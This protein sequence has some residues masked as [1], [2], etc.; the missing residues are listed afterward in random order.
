MPEEDSIVTIRSRDASSEHHKE[1]NFTGNVWL[2]Q[3]VPEK[4]TAG[5]PP[6]RRVARV[7]FAPG[8]RTNWHI[9]P[10]GQV[11]FVLSGRGFVGSDLEVIEV[12]AEDAVFTPQGVRHWHGATPDSG[13]VH[14]AVTL[15]G[16]TDW[17]DPVTSE[18][19]KKG[20]KARR[21]G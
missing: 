3:W 14:L 17:R 21:T 12:A 2:D 9:H 13:L 11:L 1:S 15:E 20:P 7:H 10:N 19:Y 16:D 4:Q 5:D 8:S 18:E 6:P